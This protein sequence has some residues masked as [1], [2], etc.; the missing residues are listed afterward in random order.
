MHQRKN[1]L[2]EV[3]GRTQ[4]TAREFHTSEDRLALGAFGR[5]KSGDRVLNEDVKV[6]PLQGRLQVGSSRATA[7]TLSKGALT[8]PLIMKYF[9]TKKTS[10]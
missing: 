1:Y 6:R 10:D 7:R 4:R 5:D 3:C 9:S 2:S 8:E